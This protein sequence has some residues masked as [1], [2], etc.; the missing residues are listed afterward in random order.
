MDS[1][2]TVIVGGGI[3]GLACA[4]RLCESN[5][6]FLLLTDRLGGRMYHRPDR[7]I[8]LGATYITE[9]YLH[10]GRYVGRGLPFRVP[11]A[12]SDVG[13][14]LTTL[15]T[16][17]NLLLTRAAIRL[18]LR[19][20]EFRA[21]L[22]SFRRRAERVAQRELLPHYPLMDRLLRQPAPELIRE[23]G[24]GR[25]HDD[26]FIRA[27]QAT[28]FSDPEQV[29]AL[30][31]LSTLL[32][33]IVRIWVADF[34]GSYARLTAGF[35][36][37]FR[38]ATVVSLRRGGDDA[39]RVGLATGQTIRARQVV[40]AMPYHNASLLYPVPRPYRSTTA[41]MLAV[42][43]ARQACYEGKPFLLFDPKVTGVILVWRQAGGEDLV[44]S[45]RPDPDLSAVFPRPV[46]TAR[47]TWKT[48]VVVSDADWA[49]L[50]LEPGLYLAGDYNLCG[51]E[52]SYLT[53]RCAANAILRDG[54][55]S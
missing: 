50:R 25:L 54:G 27:F 30:F 21:T 51:L 40:L 31:Y 7:P 53:G 22:R 47:V 11:E 33:L 42:R 3:S 14:R 18:L 23:L 13:G 29:N 6:P 32:P 1:T 52:D 19:L 39:W 44:F 26:Y 16:P 24:L 5:A 37:R 49:P 17:R 28:C 12:I 43:A 46:L 36:D 20:W 38:F 41:T 55:T 48:A 10:V 15:F 8:N 34:T 45:T 35:A 4:R 9:D 2:G